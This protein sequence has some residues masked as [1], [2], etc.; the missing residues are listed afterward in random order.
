[1]VD[2]TAFNGPKPGPWGD[3]KGFDP[4]YRQPPEFLE[5]MVEKA[6]NLYC[7]ELLLV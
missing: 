2:L 3:L 6:R 1:M 7:M 5:D 4:V